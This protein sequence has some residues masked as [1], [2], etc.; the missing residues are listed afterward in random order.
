MQGLAGHGQAFG[1][2]PRWD[3]NVHC[4]VEVIACSALKSTV[5]FSPSSRHTQRTGT[6]MVHCLLV[7]G[8]VSSGK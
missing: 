2:P 3:V 8:D 5:Y 1:F 6:T 7:S 4:Q